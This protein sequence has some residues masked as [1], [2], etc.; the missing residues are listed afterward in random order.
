MHSGTRPVMLE[1]H[2]PVHMH[3]LLTSENWYLLIDVT[4]QE[5]L[6]P[7]KLWPNVN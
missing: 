3:E 6:L 5:T 7:T 4:G 2:L 1:N